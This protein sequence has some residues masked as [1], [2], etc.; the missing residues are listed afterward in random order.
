M[1]K[2]LSIVLAIIMSLVIAVPAC[3]AENNIV[4]E[5]VTI[6]GTPFALGGEE[7]EVSPAAVDFSGRFS[8]LVGGT[9]WNKSFKVDKLVGESHNAFTVKISEVSG[10]YSL[11]ITGTN[12][13]S[14]SSG[15]KTGGT[16]VT[17]SNAVEGVTY[18][19]FIV[20]PGSQTLSGKV[21]INSYY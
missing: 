4:E 14:Y 19:V 15:L 21:T 10:Q 18:T 17:V 6:F 12:G 7:S 5:K 3:A 9:P 2:V 8:V 1:R 11:V 13:Y 20:N 16:S